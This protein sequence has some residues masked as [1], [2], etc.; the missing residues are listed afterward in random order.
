MSARLHAQHTNKEVLQNR[1][2]CTEGIPYS[3]SL[4]IVCSAKGAPECAEAA[5]NEQEVATVVEVCNQ[6][7]HCRSS[8]R[9]GQPLMTFFSERSKSF[10]LIEGN[11]SN[12][13]LNFDGADLGIQ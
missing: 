13:R 9:N 11:Q 3:L 4:T 7:R 8:S 1:P 2:E 12:V 10:Y 5:E 6:K